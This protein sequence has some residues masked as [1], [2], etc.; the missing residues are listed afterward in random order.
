MSCMQIC[1]GSKTG[2]Y[3]AKVEHHGA[4]ELSPLRQEALVG[5]GADTTMAVP[6]MLEVVPAGIN[7]WVGMRPLLADLGLPA[8]ALMACGD[9]A[10]DLQLVANAGLGIAMANAVPQVRQPGIILDVLCSSFLSIYT[11][12]SHKG[13]HY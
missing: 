1:M 10:N 6:N 13:L 12:L 9:G 5:Q 2:T 8:S 4:I 11:E 7:K 3:L